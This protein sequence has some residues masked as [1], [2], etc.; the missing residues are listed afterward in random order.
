[1][2]WAR[3]GLGAVVIAPL[4]G[5]TIVV[6]NGPPAARFP[7]DDAVR[8]LAGRPVSVR[9]RPAL[10]FFQVGRQAVITVHPAAWRAVERWAVWT[11]RDAMVATPGLPT[12]RPS[13]MVV[14]AGLDGAEAVRAGEN[15][16]SLLGNGGLDAATVLASV[17]AE[18]GLPGRDLLTGDTVAADLPGARRIVP[19]D[20]HARAFERLLDEVE[21]YSMEL[22]R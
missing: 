6:P 5:W 1:M 16:H 3:R 13:A 10:G 9:M 8:T 22:E 17:L 11:P 18:L 14:A 4:A 19:R 20:R 2:S 15:L 21:R 12:T 7:Y